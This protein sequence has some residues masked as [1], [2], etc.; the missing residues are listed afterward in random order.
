LKLEAE[1]LSKQEMIMKLLR[2]KA[3]SVID[4]GCLKWCCIFFGMIAGA[5]LSEFV[6]RYVWLFAVAA[7]LLAIKPALNYFGND[8]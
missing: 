2:T 5:Y 3:W 6:K 4:I 7:V 8:K 1:K